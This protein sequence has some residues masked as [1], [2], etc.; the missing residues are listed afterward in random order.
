LLID[1][2]LPAGTNF[3][4]NVT[5]FVD[6]EDTDYANETISNTKPITIKVAPNIA[7]NVYITAKEDKKSYDVD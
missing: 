3:T 5:A 6:Q 2:G 7:K 1:K 4:V